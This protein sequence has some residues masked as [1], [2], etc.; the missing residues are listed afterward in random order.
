MVDRAGRYFGLLFKGYSGVTQ[1][2]PL[3][4]TLFNVVMD[5]VI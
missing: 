3:S 2:D 1:Y 5:A 4:P